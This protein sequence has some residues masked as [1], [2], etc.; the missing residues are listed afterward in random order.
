[1]IQIHSEE[2]CVRTSKKPVGLLT[3]LD[4][5]RNGERRDKGIG[6]GQKGDR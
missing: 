4:K 1:M 5:R 6:C 3:V 2:E